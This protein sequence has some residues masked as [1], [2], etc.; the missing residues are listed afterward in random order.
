[1]NIQKYGFCELNRDTLPEGIKVA[2]RYEKESIVVA[3]IEEPLTNQLVEGV[4]EEEGLG[5]ARILQMHFSCHYLL[6][7]WSVQEELQ[8]MAFSDEKRVRA[9]EFLDYI[10]SDFGLVKGNAKCASGRVSIIYLRVQMSGMDIGDDMEYF[11]SMCQNY[12]EVCDWIEASKYGLDHEKDIASMDCFEKK[13]IPW[14]FVKTTDIVPLGEH[15]TLRSLENES[16]ITF[17]SNEDTYI[18][19]GCRGEIYD[20]K[21]D[22]FLCTY[23]ASEESMDVYEQMLDF[24]PEVYLEE[25]NSYV[26]LDELAKLCYPKRDAK[27]YATQLTNRT[28]VFPADGNQ[29]YYLG[30]P[31]D[32]LAIRQDDLTDLYIIQEDIFIRT[33]EKIKKG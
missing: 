16:G 19:I 18:M 4:L 2:Y 33:Y 26:M 13:R 10:I 12:F 21:K 24:L 29:E 23:D 11:L 3:S 14:A 27:I 7:V 8:L 30:R 15:I 25:R 28:K 17:V 31:G 9:Y 1:M 22:K 6:L 20:I 5:I 32:Y